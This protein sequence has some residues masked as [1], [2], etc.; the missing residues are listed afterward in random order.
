MPNNFATDSGVQQGFFVEIENISD[1]NVV[2]DGFTQFGTSSTGIGEGATVNGNAYTR[3][4]ASV[5]PAWVLSGAPEPTFFYSTIGI[6]NGRYVEFQFSTIPEPS[7]SA[8]LGIGV[9]AL[10]LRR[11]R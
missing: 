3:T 8:L 6:T 5:E 4:D 2:F 7:S 11:R 9:C 1:A 10:I